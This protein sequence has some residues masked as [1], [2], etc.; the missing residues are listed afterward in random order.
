M[1]WQFR[2]ARRCRAEQSFVPIRHVE[3]RVPD[4]RGG[5]DHHRIVPE[6]TV[7]AAGA[8]SAMIEPG[9]KV[10]TF[11]LGAPEID[12]FVLHGTLPIPPN[13]FP[14]RDGSSPFQIRDPERQRPCRRRR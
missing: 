14:T 8:S 12:G 13:I 7:H 5:D 11:E 1:G 10:A 2:T 3:R 4:R 6:S 9:T